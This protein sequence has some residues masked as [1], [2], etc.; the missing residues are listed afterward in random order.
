MTSGLI[1]NDDWLEG[2]VGSQGVGVEESFCSN[3]YEDCMKI[4][5]YGLWIGM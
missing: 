2:G 1:M 4:A 3:D 5:G